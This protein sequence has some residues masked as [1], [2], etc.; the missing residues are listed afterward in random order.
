MAIDAGLD[1]LCE[2][3]MAVS[4][5]AAATVR[6]ASE[7]S[8]RV[9][10]VGYKNRF[11][12]LMRRLHDDVRDGVFGTP[13]LI[14][15]SVF[16][17][18]WRRQDEL[19]TKRIAGFLDEGPAF[20]HNG[21]HLTDYMAWTL[22]SPTW[23][24]GTGHR[25]REEARTGSYHAAIYRFADA[26]IGRLEVGWWYPQVFES[27][28]QVYGPLAVADLSRPRGRLTIDRGEG[29]PEVVK[30]TEDWQTV[31]FR[32]QWAS[33]RS[34]VIERRA[35][36]PGVEAACEA[37][38]LTLAVA[39]SDAGGEPIDRPAGGWGAAWGDA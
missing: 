1:V 13:L 5:E 39:A 12:P 17:E 29:A 37:L 32:G 6:Q 27:E 33:F 14:R 19:H 21:V 25:I 9:V 23:V 10:Q 34:A 2:K 4:L 8:D 7:R 31:C 22:G 3:P 30:E 35:P 24:V 20:V 36:E 28:L 18:I 38:G 11:H 26:S 16:D 15:M